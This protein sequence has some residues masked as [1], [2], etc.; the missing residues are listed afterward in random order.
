MV[1]CLAFWGSLPLI[2]SEPFPLSQ[3]LYKEID[4]WT[5]LP[6]GVMAKGLKNF[7]ARTQRYEKNGIKLKVKLTV[8]LGIKI[9][10]K[11]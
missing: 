7:T 6:Q 3:L 10:S 2:N 8:H 4:E 1:A 11:S 5:S 9:H